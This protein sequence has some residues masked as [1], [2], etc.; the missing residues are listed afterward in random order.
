[1]IIYK[2]KGGV[3]ERELLDQYKINSNYNHEKI[4]NLFKNF[5]TMS[6]LDLVVDYKDLL[7]NGYNKR[8]LDKVYIQ[9]YHCIF[10]YF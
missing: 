4:T 9:C 6:F 10:F 3:F 7:N 5:D 2:L 1:M 8:F